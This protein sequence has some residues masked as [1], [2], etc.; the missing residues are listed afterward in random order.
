MSKQRFIEKNSSRLLDFEIS[1]VQNLSEDKVYFCGLSL[2][3]SELY[4]KQTKGILENEVKKNLDDD[5]GYYN[6]LLG[7]HLNYRYEIIK[8]LGKGS[9]A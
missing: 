6:V 4:M 9:F 3:R 7:D 5:E 2:Q 1:E 8:I